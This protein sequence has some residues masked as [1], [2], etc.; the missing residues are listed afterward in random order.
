MRRLL[1]TLVFCGAAFSVRAA[2]S[3]A[4][5]STCASD[6]GKN[7]L[8]LAEA[9]LSGEKAIVLVERS[10]VERILQEWKLWQCGLGDPNQAL[11]AGRQL[12]V[13]VFAML[14]VLPG[15]S[16]A[17][18]LVCFDAGTGV[19]LADVTLPVAGLDAA[20]DS[21]VTTVLAACV[22]N[23]QTGTG[24]RAVSLMPVRNAD[25]TAERNGFCETVDLLVERQLIGVP[26]LAVL[27]RGRL[28]AVNMD[29]DLPA[30]SVPTL[31]NESLRLIELEFSRGGLT[32][33]LQVRVTQKDSTGHQTMQTNVW[34]AGLDPVALAQSL[35][36][37]I[38]RSLRTIPTTN[39]IDRLAEARRFNA[40]TEFY[41]SYREYAPALRTAEAA[42][43]LDPANLVFRA[44]LTKTLFAVATLPSTRDLPAAADVERSIELTERGARY[45]LDLR[46]T[47]HENKAPDVAAC[48][49]ILSGLSAEPCLQDMLARY[50]DHDNFIRNIQ[51]SGFMVQ[52]LSNVVARG[53]LH[54][55]YNHSPVWEQFPPH[56]PCTPLQT[57]WQ[58][59][60]SAEIE[61]AITA[62]QA[63]WRTS[64]ADR[65]V[66]EILELCRQTKAFEPVAPI[67]PAEPPED[68]ELAMLQ[69][70]RRKLMKDR[71]SSN[72]IDRAE[73][74]RVKVQAAIAA[75]DPPLSATKRWP[76]YYI[77]QEL[78]LQR[79]PDFQQFL[80][81]Q[82]DF[83]WELI[84]V[85]HRPFEMAN[86]KAGAQQHRL[87]F[88][89]GVLAKI[90]EPNLRWERDRERVRASCEY[91]RSILLRLHPELAESPSQPPWTEA[92]KLMECGSLSDGN[93]IR[94]IFTPQVSENAIYVLGLGGSTSMRARQEVWR[95]SYFQLLRCPADGGSVT[96][97]GKFEF[98]PGRPAAVEQSGWGLIRADMQSLAAVE[99][100]PAIYWRGCYYAAPQ[101]NYASLGVLAFPTN[102]GPVKQIST[103][104]GLPI[105]AVRAMAG[106]DDTLLVGMDDF[107]AAYNPTTQQC[108]ILASS[109]RREKLSPFDNGPPFVIP[110]LV[111]DP[112]RHRIVFLFN[113][114]EFWEWNS[115][116]RQFRQLLRQPTGYHYYRGRSGALS[117]HQFILSNFK[118]TYEFDL[119]TDQLVPLPGGFG[120]S[121]G[122]Q[123]P[124][125]GWIW[126]ASPW[127]RATP[128]G[129][130]K[131]LFP[132]LRTP[133][134]VDNFFWPY[135]CLMPINDGHQVVVSD[136]RTLWLLTL[137]DA[138]K[139]RPLNKLTP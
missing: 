129:R 63:P 104:A 125:N 126:S 39:T 100:V 45:L 134:T 79:E 56:G 28:G 124:L 78:G 130:Q 98:P 113:S 15:E 58:T 65:G 87:E 3:V 73:A 6:T 54:D 84:R 117:D 38:A 42:C 81:E 105:S 77:V 69:D 33:G 76:Y 131:Q 27:E 102:G 24:Y 21:I 85:G 94:N 91:Q 112:P 57:Y 110:W 7:M 72:W 60:K 109:R 108:D 64:E 46:R 53:E 30:I 71:S 90:D 106:L 82:K 115:Q 119:A 136:E 127:G 35:T 43:A 10:Q 1:L 121:Y 52:F 41:S 31:L 20:V 101:T 75:A 11:V 111:A 114:D 2:T 120:E 66:R 132:S 47:I 89:T 96:P 95:D 97:L 70:L 86:E 14:E 44:V 55:L 135:D 19:R 123:L 4:L 59:G 51:V 107:L 103:G 139:D 138:A 116:T 9:R 137:P 88:V 68:P 48:S 23:Q 16:N 49:Q 13:Q 8:A 83:P 22:K 128:D 18:G 62:C 17:L 32:T 133:E 40:E 12:G 99:F 61:E 36:A 93:G 67:A 80:L 74:L 5:V 122:P 34:T 25:L 50:C 92:H 118:Q 29:R 37:V 26:G